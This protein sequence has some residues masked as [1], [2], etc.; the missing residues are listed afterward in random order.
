M[1]LV[2]Q[3]FSLISLSDPF[4]GSLKQD[5]AEFENWFQRKAREGASAY[6]FYGDHGSIEGF[7]Y[8]KREDDAVTDVAPP[9]P[10][11]PRVKVGTFKVNAH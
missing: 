1:S 11:M 9:L 3:P 4:F 6:V 2:S 10:P 5:Y 8:L 7:L